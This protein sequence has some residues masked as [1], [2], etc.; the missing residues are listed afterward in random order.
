MLWCVSPKVRQFEK[1]A[2][3]KSTDGNL[4]GNYLSRDIISVICDPAIRSCFGVFGSSQ[5][6]VGSIVLMNTSAYKKSASHYSN[7]NDFYD[8]SQMA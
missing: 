5:L 1:S 6:R 3:K 4:R 7:Q 2:S 8:R